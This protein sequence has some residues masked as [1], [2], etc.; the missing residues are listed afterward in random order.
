MRVFAVSVFKKAIF[1][2]LVA[3]YAAAG[4]FAQD[5]KPDET[6]R[7]DTNLIQ[8][9]VT[10]VDKAGH[11]VDGLKPE[12]FVLKID[13]K[14]VKIDFFDR[15]V[16]YVDMNRTRA[17][18]ESG[19]KTPAG[20]SPVSLRERRIVFF[21]DDFHLSLEG[22]GRARSAI[23]HFISYDML[24]RDQV[25][26]VTATGNLGFLQQFTNNKP[27]LLAAVAR[28]RVFPD[29]IRDTEPPP[30]PEYIAV[31]IVNNDAQAAEYYVEKIVGAKRAKNEVLNRGAVFEMVKRRAENIV[32]SM[33]HATKNTLYSLENLLLNTGLYSGR[34]IVF[35]ISDG[36]YL[37]S[38][39]T[40]YATTEGLERSINLA[41]RSGSSVYTIDARGLFSSAIGEAT[42]ERPFDPQGRL[43]KSATGE[44]MAS[45]DG[46]ATLANET[47]GRFLKNQN[48]FDKW[49]DRVIDENSSYYVLAWT[50]EKDEQLTRKFKSIEVVISGRPDLKVRQQRGYLTV[51]DKPKPE[52]RSG[53]ASAKEADSKKKLPILLS[54][55]YLDIPN[56]GGVL[57][58]SV[59]V[60]TGGLNYGVK[61]DQPAVLQ[62]QGVIFNEDDKQVG[63]F[64][65][66]L[67]ID[68]PGAGTD[69]PA[70][71][72]VIYNEK[73]PLKPGLYQVKVGVREGPA[74][75]PTLANQWIE[76]PDLSKNQLTLG[77]IFLGGKLIESDKPDNAAAQ[78][79]F[80]VD[81]RFSNPVSLNFMSFVY[82]AA[83]AGGGSGEVNLAT[84]IEVLNIDGQAVIDTNLRPLATKGNTDMTRIPV[85]GSIKQAAISPGNYLLRVTVADNIANT[86]AVQ[87][88]F[89]TIE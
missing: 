28:L 32:S 36:F 67:T 72:S 14:P 83:R 88:T 45:Q 80:S 65:Q 63:T 56:V 17:G 60:A 24:P 21:I 47:G 38:K 51:W 62:F 27:M 20:S 15:V 81:H 54:L 78:I 71:Q 5:D 41:T 29:T 73:T 82:N 34:K 86:K 74:G 44:D 35:L 13:G 57:S 61:N 18:Q 1:L 79:Q 26:I 69:P 16:S 66:G 49:I 9:D 3:I 85:R 55:N 11:F 2:S 68:P 10:V 30:M 48:Y 46:M 64:Q 25:Q 7:I 43:D 40:P 37:E 23:T 4:V 33:A 75:S 19:Q 59:Q 42:N 89:F 77:S 31:Q 84:R 50:P 53:D 8:T 22:L 70:D 58:S 12:Q 6:I 76:I 52:T 39:H 87:Q